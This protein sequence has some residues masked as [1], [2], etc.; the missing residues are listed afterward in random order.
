MSDD[1]KIQAHGVTYIITKGDRGLQ[2]R[3]SDKICVDPENTF[4]VEIRP[5]ED[6]KG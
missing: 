3:A 4:T 2:I 6:Q 1:V 5:R